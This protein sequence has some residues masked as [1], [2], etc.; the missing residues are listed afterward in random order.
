VLG[1]ALRADDHRWVEAAHQGA[2]G[3]LL[4]ARDVENAPVAAARVMSN[5][6]DDRRFGDTW[7]A[8]QE[9]GLLEL[10]RV[11][12]QPQLFPSTDYVRLTF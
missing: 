11:E 9:H 12:Q 7:E 6:A 8:E 2:R 3:E 1:L 10:D 4:V 5:S